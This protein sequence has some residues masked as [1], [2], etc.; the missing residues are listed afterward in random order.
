ML[1]TDPVFASVARLAHV[2]TD[3][4]AAASSEQLQ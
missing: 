3:G 2:T 1:Y 4:H